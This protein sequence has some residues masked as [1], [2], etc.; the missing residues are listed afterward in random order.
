GYANKHKPVGAKSIPDKLFGIAHI[1]VSAHH[2]SFTNLYCWYI[3]LCSRTPWRY[4]IFKFSIEGALATLTWER[5][6]VGFRAPHLGI[7][8]GQ[9]LVMQGAAA[10]A[11]RPFVI[12]VIV[13]IKRFP[14][15][16]MSR[17]ILCMFVHVGVTH[18]VTI[19]SRRNL[20]EI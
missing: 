11:T 8:I 1:V 13:V 2:T 17:V 14:C 12:V 3:R 5:L 15:I 9:I 4:R 6:Y 19:L 16:H 7:H 18:I 10:R 20:V